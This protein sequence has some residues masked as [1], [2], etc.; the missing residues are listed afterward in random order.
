M[1]LY[2]QFTDKQ[3]NPIPLTYHPLNT[4]IKK[5]IYNNY[6]ILSGDPNIQ[7]ILHDPPLMAFRRDIIIRDSLDHTN[8]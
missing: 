5:I 2:C 6:H 1:I 4:G 7:E 3:R 8:L